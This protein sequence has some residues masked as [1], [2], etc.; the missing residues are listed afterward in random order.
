MLFYNLKLICCFNLLTVLIFLP[1][2]LKQ[3]VKISDDITIPDEVAIFDTYFFGSLVC[4][5][6]CSKNKYKQE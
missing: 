2:L 6:Y 3:L 4:I 1:I 5:V